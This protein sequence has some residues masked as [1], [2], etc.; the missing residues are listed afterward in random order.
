MADEQIK[1]EEVKNEVAKAENTQPQV[2]NRNM[3]ADL[4]NGVYSSSDTFK[5]AMQMA[6]GLAASTIVP[7]AYQK[8]EANCLVA[9]EMA[10]RTG[11]SPIQ[12]MQSLDVIQGTPAW[13][14]KALIAMVNNSHKYDED[15]H[16]EYTKDS[17]GEV[18]GCYAWTKKD[19]HEVKG[20]EYTYEMAK[21]A[22][23]FE[24]NN[25]YWK[26]EPE[27]M[28]AYRAISRFCSLNCPEISL[29]LYTTDE[30]REIYVTEP[31]KKA[32]VKTLLADG[33][34]EVIDG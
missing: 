29:G 16:F 31:P 22:K 5:L 13:R 3:V 21:E 33:D 18:K 26:K 4:S 14:G 1:T 34:V 7:V 19:G 6:K 2:A 32:D 28:L 23:L 25:S 12:I 30:A 20:T 10:N 9:L 27:L 24:K 17:K 15:I 11:Q 8:N